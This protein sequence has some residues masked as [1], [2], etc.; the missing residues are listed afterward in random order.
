MVEQ[1]HANTHMNKDSCALPWPR[2][3]HNLTCFPRLLQ[4][5]LVPKANQNPWRFT[6]QHASPAASRTSESTRRLQLQVPPHL[7][8][9]HL[10]LDLNLNEHLGQDAAPNPTLRPVAEHALCWLTA[11]HVLAAGTGDISAVSTAELLAIVQFNLFLTRRLLSAVPRHEFKSLLQHNQRQEQEQEQEHKSTSSTQ[12]TTTTHPNTHTHETKAPLAPH[13]NQPR[14]FE[15]ALWAVFVF[16]VVARA[17]PLC[18]LFVSHG[19]CRSSAQN[20]ARAPLSMSPC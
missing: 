16:V 19:G 5:S 9:L 18:V 11:K 14:R 15:I 6:L 8:Q 7:A 12:T 20:G 17:K 4:H 1:V 13:T 3:C 2:L 10:G